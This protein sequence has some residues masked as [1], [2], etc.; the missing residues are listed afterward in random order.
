MSLGRNKGLNNRPIWS[1]FVGGQAG[2]KV[3]RNTN[4]HNNTKMWKPYKDTHSDHK[5]IKEITTGH[6]TTVKTC[7]TTTNKYKMTQKKDWKE[8]KLLWSL[9]VWLLFR[10]GCGAFSLSESRGQ[11]SHKQPMY[12][13]AIYTHCSP[14]K[15]LLWGNSKKLFTAAILRRKTTRVTLIVE[16]LSRKTNHL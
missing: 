14:E 2:N 9:C 13:H 1:F 5:E 3:Q 11:L 6:K 16:T 4:D 15:A 7:K 12:T 10:R 8:A